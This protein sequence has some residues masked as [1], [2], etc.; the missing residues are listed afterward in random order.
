[1]GIPARVR[2][3]VTEEERQGLRERAQI[4]ADRGAIYRELLAEAERTA[5]RDE[6][7]S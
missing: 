4:Y 1:M 7:G 5:R 6:H 3:D 2:R